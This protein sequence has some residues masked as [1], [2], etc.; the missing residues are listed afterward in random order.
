MSGLLNSKRDKAWW[1]RRVKWGLVPQMAFVSPEQRPGEGEER[2][3]GPFGSPT[4]GGLELVA[5]AKALGSACT[6]FWSSKADEPGRVQS[7]AP[8]VGNEQDYEALQG[9]WIC[10]VS[11][12]EG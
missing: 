4:E 1:E 9:L 10:M 12:A 2:R 3:E 6:W 5:C 11:R 8:A 7:W